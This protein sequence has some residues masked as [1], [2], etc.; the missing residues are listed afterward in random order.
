MKFLSHKDPDKLLIDHL[1]EVKKYACQNCDIYKDEVEL[2]CLLH[3]FGKYTT[4][5]Q[6]HLETGLE[7]ENSNHSFISAVVC[8]Y[9][10]FKR[11]ND[12][13]PL[14]LYS[15]IISHHGDIKELSDTI[16]PR[17]ISNINSSDDY[18]LLTKIQS[19]K[20]QMEDIKK[21]KDNIINDY[22]KTSIQFD[23]ED[24]FNNINYDIIIE[25]LL[26]LKKLKVK[27]DCFEQNKDSEELYFMHNYIYSKLIWAD[28][29]S[30][31][32]V[33]PIEEKFCKYET[34]NN[35][36]NNI[37][38]E[39]KSNINDIRNNIYNCVINKL[40]KNYKN[41][42]Y[43]ITAP[44]GTGKTYTGFL[45]ANKLKEISNMSG[46][47]IYSL[48]YT[49]IIDQNYKDIKKI[50]SDLNCDGTDYIMIHH[51]LS[52]LKFESKE[53]ENEDYNIM[54]VQQLYE[55]WNSGVIVT[56]FVQLIQT[57][58]SSKNRML[59]KFNKLYNSVILIDEIQSMDIHI[60]KLVER[61]LNDAIKYLNCKVIIMT[62]TKPIIFEDAIELLDNNQKYFENMNRTKLIYQ[63]SYI[64]TDEFICKFINKYDK[65]KSYMIVCNTINESLN[66]FEKMYESKL[67]EKL[68]YLSANLISKDKKRVIKNI[69]DIQNGKHTPHILITTQVVEAG[70]NFDFDIVYR[71]IS[72]LTSI[73]Q[74]SGRCNRAGKNEIGEVHIINLVNDK[75]KLY[76]EYVY[77]CN[78][79][80]ITK[81][82]LLSYSNNPIYEKDFYSIIYQY[83]TQMN[84]LISENESNEFIKAIQNIDFDKISEFSL[85]K[86]NGIYNDVF[87]IIDEHAKKL[88]SK[89][90]NILCL[91][92]KIERKKE[93]LEI[94]AEVDDYTVSVREETARKCNYNEKLDVYYVSKE[95]CTDSVDE[96]KRYS[97][98]TGFNKKDVIID[99]FL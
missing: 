25:I 18:S 38:K 90:I 30:A 12:Y 63:D 45:A 56:T 93:L 41:D 92:D 86:N 10:A 1:L 13:T 82:I 3:D 42:K 81:K 8:A 19:A 84:E 85:I 23:I 35:S 26:K 83:F 53:N 98:I 36:K 39:C 22:K 40:E 70:V 15:A 2:V 99:S 62:A 34:L 91:K 7:I 75:G 80:A 27:L 37:V 65:E 66:I 95:D 87:C 89:Y 11:Y 24:V 32:R 55:G 31:S 73:V 64:R 68:Y 72:P 54:Q 46:R 96:L 16:L 88:F 57:L 49:S 60:Y 61:V 47:I 71:D 9:I 50:Y 76:S 69:Q 78:E 43:T 51:H 52:E 79:L 6:K 20:I 74:A 21:N 97:E 44:T 17:N 28:K 14:I 48:P 5:F 94:R 77:D 29:M 67:C 58:I 59:K 4:F 33:I